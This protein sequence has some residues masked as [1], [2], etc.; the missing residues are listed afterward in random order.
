[1]PVGTDCL[2]RTENTFLRAIARKSGANVQ[3]LRVRLGERAWL[4]LFDFWAEGGVI[5]DAFLMLFWTLRKPSFSSLPLLF[6]YLFLVA[7]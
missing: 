7:T 2:I 5:Q 1:M 3:Q 6:I 4:F